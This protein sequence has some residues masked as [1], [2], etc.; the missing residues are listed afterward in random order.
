MSKA[1]PHDDADEL[2]ELPPLDPSLEEE[3]EGP[4]E[5]LTPLAQLVEEDLDLDEDHPERELDVALEM[6]EESSD[7]EG[8]EVVLDIQSLLSLAGEDEHD[9]D[10]DRAGPVGLDPAA[11]LSDS[12]EPIV[13]SLEEGTDEPLEE[14]VSDDLPE[15]DA[16]E[17]GGFE[18]E[19]SWLASDALRDEDLPEASERPW[20]V[21][22]L[23]VLGNDL[24]A[25]AFGEGRLWV[26]GPRLVSL[27]LE[28]SG[29]RVELST[30][31]LALVGLASC[32]LALTPAGELE[33]VTTAAGSRRVQ[34][35]REA[36]ALGDDAAA[37]LAAARVSAL[38]PDAVLL[39]AGTHRVALSRDAGSSFEATEL[40]GTVVAVSSD[41]PALVLTRG[42]EGWALLEWRP[43][44]VTRTPLGAA[45]EEIAAGEEVHLG[46]RGNVVAMTGADRGL[47]VSDDGGASWSRVPGCLHASALAVGE[48]DGR[49]RVWLCAFIESEERS[50]VIEVD[51]ATRRAEVIAELGPVD[52]VAPSDGEDAR[53]HALAW[54]AERGWLW[55]AGATGLHRLTAPEHSA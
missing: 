17:P 31:A 52:D 46:A 8:H 3:R 27:D 54:D 43:T 16:D 47:V 19:S 4:D 51:V 7:D 48:R 2:A 35:F 1:D 53:L 22:R 24:E 55:A 21:E 6:P 12:D 41:E 42:A 36:L 9:E 44:R 11:D 14:L 10:A 38:G 13:G 45:A 37:P 34:G 39:A 50:L 18:N 33:R 29:A 28:G 40:G 49:A 26:A 15:L 5:P 30:K 20:R 25:L 32:V 23:D